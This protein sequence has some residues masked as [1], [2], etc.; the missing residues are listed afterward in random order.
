MISFERPTP[1]LGTERDIVSK[2]VTAFLLD[3]IVVAVLLG[4]ATNAAFAFRDPLEFVVAAVVAAV[5]AVVGAVLAFVYFILFEARYGQTI[6]KMV[7]DIVVIGEDDGSISYRE[8]TTRTLLRPLDVIGFVA[9]YFTDRKQRLG[10]LAADTV[11]VETKEK[12]EPL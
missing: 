3:V 8:A 5:V 1:N 6:G 11:V 9:I 7:M 2:R 12:P 10:D 4:V